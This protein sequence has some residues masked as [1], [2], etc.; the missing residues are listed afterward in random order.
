MAASLA[1]IFNSIQMKRITVFLFVLVSVSCLAQRYDAKKGDFKNLK[2]IAEFNVTFDYNGQIVNG[3]DT[4]EEFLNEKMHKREHREG[5]AE[6]FHEDWF[7]NR[8]KQYEPAFVNYFN[9]MF[10]DGQVKVGKNPEAKYTMHLKTTWVYPGYNAGTDIGPAK[11]SA[12]ITVSE[13]YN[14]ANILLMVEFDKVI[15]LKH[16]IMTNTLG[17]R[18]SWAYE[19][20]AKNLALQLKRFL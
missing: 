17:D 6:K 12:I 5:A 19:K 18:I 20:L 1:A 16:D 11:V 9:K 4:E 2:G 3:F 13:T 10:K 15:G 8:E 7:S 14:P